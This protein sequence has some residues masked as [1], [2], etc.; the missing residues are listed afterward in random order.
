M[1]LPGSSQ[2]PPGVVSA[3]TPKRPCPYFVCSGTKWFTSSNDADE[4]NEK[5]VAPA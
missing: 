1:L 4:R 3:S 5:C 2:A